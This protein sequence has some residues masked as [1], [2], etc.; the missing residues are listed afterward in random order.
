MV[1]WIT[2]ALM[3]LGMAVA[4]YAAATASRE[5]PKVPLSAQPS[6]NPFQN[7]IAATGVVEASSR[8]ISISAPDG[9]LVTAVMAQVGQTVKIGDPLFELDPRPLKADLI[10]AQAARDAAAAVLERVKAQPRKE[11]VPP[12]EAAAAS[13][14]AEVADW[15]DQ[16][17]RFEDAVRQTSAGDMEL[18][19]RRF[20]LEGAK[21]RLAQAEAN[22][23]LTTA[24]PWSR[25]LD[26]AVAELA[27]AQAQ[28]DAAQVLLERRTVRSPIDGTV[29]KRNVEPGQ[30]ASAEPRSAAMVIGDLRKLHIRARV[31]EEDLPMLR[32]G[33]R[34]EA[35][36]RGRLPVNLKLAMLRIEPLAQPKTELSGD[37]TERVDT[38]V[39]EVVFEVESGGVRLYPGQLLDVFIEGAA[40]AGDPPAPN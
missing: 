24:G 40:S 12:L 3:V 28:V 34:G 33:A 10:R 37:T 17:T 21:A 30:F 27:L 2:L 11:T 9:G 35:R 25:D 15:A 23:A 20:G 16:I 39:L 18:M 8:N 29:L 26:V 4:V 19:R 5:A 13:A 36:V 38:R 14:R 22:L 32:E 31:D 6:V 1:K 7:G